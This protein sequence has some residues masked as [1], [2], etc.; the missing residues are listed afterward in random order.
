ML[1]RITFLCL[2][3]GLFFVLSAAAPPAQSSAE[4]GWNK[5]SNDAAR[6]VEHGGTERAFSGRFLRHKQKGTYTCARCDAPL[7]ASTTKFTSGT[8]WPSFDQ[9]I[10]GAVKEVPDADGQRVEIRCNRCDGHLGHVF[11]GEGF[12]KKGTRHCV[13]SAALGFAQTP[14]QEAFFAGGCFWGV[15]HLLEKIP[16]VDKVESGYMGGS[17]KAPSY[18]Q[19]ITGRSGHAETVR[20]TFDPSRVSYEVLAKAFFE[21]HD[22]TQLNRQGPDRG[23]QYRSAVFV[24][25]SKQEQVIAQLIQIL[26]KK[27]LSVVTA[28]EPA[29]VFWPAE[30]YHQDYYVRTGKAPYCHQHT[31]RFD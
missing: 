7:F 28:V 30:A 31:K 5:L 11:R 6:V 23:H 25:D 21:I 24:T 12:T 22:P 14:R 18:K 9:A 10:A 8:G 4:H 17:L 27:G 16:G 3:C 15:E 29:G 2:F 20:V 1:I 19:V 13:N 26:R